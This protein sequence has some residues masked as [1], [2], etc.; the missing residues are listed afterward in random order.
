MVVSKYEYVGMGIS[1][2]FMVLALYLVRLETSLFSDAAPTQQLASAGIVVVN[3]GDDITNERVTALR[4]AT[5][6]RGNLQKMVIDDVKIGTGVEVVEGDTVVVH[7]VGRLQNG[8]EFDNSNKRGEPLTF[9]IGEGR[10]I[11]GWEEGLIGMKVGGQR[12]LAI[13]PEMAYGD[14]A[15]GPIP[16]NSTL[17]FSIEL[18]EI[19][20]KN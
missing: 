1:V 13:P 10:V 17:I 20:G 8:Q 11:Q 6:A 3:K 16:P 4:E 18:I 15:V 7:Y 19:E 12:I 14:R 9:T 2:L 5:D